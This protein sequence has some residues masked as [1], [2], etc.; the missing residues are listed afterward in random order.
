M[1]KRLAGWSLAV[2]A[3]AGMVVEWAAAAV[4]TA[5]YSFLRQAVSD[6]GATTCGPLTY[7]DP[8]TQV[9]SPAHGWV[10]GVWIVAG[11]V[12]AASVVLL[13]RHLATERRRRSATWGAGMLAAGGLFQAA[14]GAVPLD[15]DLALHTILALVGFVAQNLGLILAGLALRGRAGALAG[16]GIVGGVIGLA[17]L[18]LFVAPTSWALPLGLIERISMYPYPIWLI[19]AGT[20]VATGKGR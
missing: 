9:C 12:I 6:L 20:I 1:L 4:S 16:A 7:T 11:L 10:N 2:A 14:V 17:S 3:V 15:V 18:L 13:R 5:P 8:P 19:A